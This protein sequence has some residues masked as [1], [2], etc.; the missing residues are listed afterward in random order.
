MTDHFKP[1]NLTGRSH[2]N[3]VIKK[4]ISEGVKVLAEILHENLTE[5]HALEK[6]VELIA[7]YGRRVN[8]GCLTNAT[9]G[10]EGSSGYVATPETRRKLSLSNTGKTHSRE[11]RDKISSANAGRKMPS[12]SVMK[13]AE[14]NRGRKRTARARMNMS[15]AQMGRVFSS[16]HRENLSIAKKGNHLS[17]DHAKANK[18]AVW[19][20]NPSWMKA[21]VI[22]DAWSKN[23]T[24]HTSLEKSTG[25]QKLA[26][27]C[28]LFKQGWNPSRDQDWIEYS[29]R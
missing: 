7:F 23:K 8:G 24:G 3:N 16:E 20:R 12:E 9:D 11:T 21:D 28:L 26:R 17:P 15:S 2:K 10:G 29:G 19:R 6:E 14:A 22:H 18:F 1:S 5:E 25:Y 13:T 4:A 27:M